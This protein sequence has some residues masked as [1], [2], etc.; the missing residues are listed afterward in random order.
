MSQ[1]YREEKSKEETSPES[2]ESIKLKLGD[3]IEIIAPTNPL[4]HQSHF[5]IQYIN[6]SRIQIINVATLEETQ[7]TIYK[8]TGTF[9]DES[10][11]EILLVNRSPVP[12]YARQN[13]L[14]SGTWIEIHIAGEVST[15]ITGE[16]TS[17][18]EDQ[19]EITTYP[20]LTVIYID[21]EYKGLPEDI[22]IKKIIIRDKPESLK[23]IKSLGDLSQE[24]D[25]SPMSQTDPYIEYLETGEVII[26]AE[27]TAEAEENVITTLQSLV[28]KSKGIVY[29]EDLEDITQLI[30]IP[31][32]K[33]Q[34]T[35]DAQI[36]SML[37]ELLSTIPTAQR[38]KN[39]VDK[40]NVLINRY[41]ELRAVFS[42]FDENGNVRN[43]KK[44]DPNFHK[45]LVEHIKQMDVKLKWVLPS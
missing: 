33:K 27:E 20:D 22:P 42:V 37:D 32:S 23:R 6:E 8:E 24:E 18:E 38:S 21:F 16:I 25:T 4:L 29:G 31:E 30:E 9:T 34:Y 40:I 13:N 15:I 7:L 28:A 41:R 26:N 5:F 3:I 43:F 35:I 36:N 19:I 2:D 1:E 17:L 11:T 44:N 45:P 10:I 39:I 12:G 14:L